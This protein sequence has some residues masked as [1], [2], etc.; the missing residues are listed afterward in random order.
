MT[1]TN[2]ETSVLETARHESEKIVKAAEQA[3]RDRT[4]HEVDAYRREAEQQQQQAIRAA[5]EGAARRLLQ[6]KGVHAKQVLEHRNALLARVFEEA[7][8]RILELPAEKYASVMTRRLTRTTGSDGGR[9]RVHPREKAVFESILLSWNASRPKESRVT[10]DEDNPL[11]ERGGFIFV[12]TAYEVDQTL[13]AILNDMEYAL[14]PEI[15]AEM[16]H[17]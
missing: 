7:R 1:F 2:I 8:K 13:D 17:G 15:G 11:Q 5:E 3:A 12:G 4:T 9:I 16:F 10:I 14:A 6:A